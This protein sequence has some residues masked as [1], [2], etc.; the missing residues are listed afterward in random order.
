MLF[1]EALP[2]LEHSEYHPGGYCR[3]AF[4]LCEVLT[5]IGDIDQAGVYRSKGENRAQNFDAQG[6]GIGA[7]SYEQFVG[8]PHR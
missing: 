3:T 6:L 2:I 8:Y 4:A 1:K 5:R 7:K